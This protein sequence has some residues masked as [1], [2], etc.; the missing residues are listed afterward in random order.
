MIKKKLRIAVLGTRGIP[1]VMGGVESHCEALYPRLAA[2]GHHVTL[3]ARRR[4]VQDAPYIYQGVKIEPL[5]SP[6]K[7]NLETICYT[8]HGLL[9]IAAQKSRF[10]LLHI[11]GIGPSLLM[12]VATRMGL[13]VVMTHH[14]QNYEHKKWSLAG[15]KALKLGERIACGKADAVIAVSKYVLSILHKIYQRNA[16]YIPNGVVLPDII[17]PGEALRRYKL[18]ARNYFLA[19]GRFVQEKGF[20][21]LIEAFSRIK[22]NWK[23]VIAGKADHPDEYSGSIEAWAA[24]DDRVVLTGFIKG[25]E[26][27][28]IYSN[29]G[30]FVLPS[31]H[32]GL[33][34]V[35]LEAMSYNLPLLASDIPVNKELV[36]KEELFPVGDVNA[37]SLRMAGYIAQPGRRIQSRNK[38]AAEFDWDKVAEKTEQVYLDLFNK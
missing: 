37:L 27:A 5:M 21:Y 2:K 15:K 29:A 18:T 36:S 12:P 16:I 17:G 23:L 34:I 20:Q 19:V 4:Y 26:L 25:C 22:T 31:Y 9:R 24:L 32:E 33:P 1:G 30:L 7:K 35:I 8:A 28:E 11:H 14:G 38:M 10:D 6:K 13:K 3:F